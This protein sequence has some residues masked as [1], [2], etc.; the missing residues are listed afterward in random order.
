[1]RRATSVVTSA[2][3]ALLLAACGGGGG[4][5]SPDPV[6]VDYP[7][8]YIERP[9]P[10]DGDQALISDDLVRPEAFA[11]GARLL[12]RERLS[13]SAAERDLTPRLYGADVLVDIADLTV[14]HDGER[15][16]FAAR[17]PLDPDGDPD[18]QPPWAL[19]EYNRSSDSLRRLI[20]DDRIAAAGH[21][22][23]PA[24]LADGRIIFSSSRQRTG[25]AILLD[26]GRP[27]YS[28]D[29]E[30][31]QG[32]AFN[33]HVMDADGDNLTQ[34]TFNQ[35]HD[36]APLVTA[37][38]R[39]NYLRWDRMPGRD[40][41]HLYRMEPGGHQAELRY[42]WHSHNSGTD[43]DAIDYAR[44]LEDG[45]GRLLALIRRRETDYYGGDL[46]YI[47][48][49]NFID[50]EQTTADGSGSSGQWSATF[51]E[52]RTDELPSPAGRIHS[53]SAMFDDSGRLLLSWSPCRM[54]LNA[55]AEPP[56]PIAPCTADN[57]A[58]AGAEPAEPLYGIWVYNPAEQTQR[59]VVLARSGRML[60]EPVVMQARP[61]PAFRADPP[62]GEGEGELDSRGVAEGSAILAIRSVYDLD[63]VDVAP[64][65]I[66]AL[67]DPERTSSDERPVHFV[68]FWRG[69]PMP[70][71]DVVD[72]DN[73]AF[74]V[75]GGQL[76][77]ELVG[78]A[79]VEPD[80]SVKVRLPANVALALELTD[81]EGKRVGPRHLQWLTLQSGEQR[82][83]NGCHSAASTLPHGR[84]DAEAPSAHLGAP[85]TG[86]PYP[87]T[88]PARFADAGETMAEIVAR[89]DGVPSVAADLVKADLWTDPAVRTPDPDI[90]LR[91]ADMAAGVPAGSSCF[92][93]WLPACRISHDYPTS[94]QP[95]WQAER[96]QLDELEMEVANYRCT[97]CHAP[98]DGDG[99]AQLPA[100]Q[101]DLSASPS[102]DQPQQAV[103]FRE[104]LFGD[105]EQE[106]VEG[107]V[108]DRL[109][110]AVD[111]NGDP[112]YQRD[113]NGELILDEN[114]EPIPV[115]V[116]VA[117]AAPLNAAGASNNDLF[118]DLFAADGSHA[119]YLNAA[120]LKQI[121]E[122]L[123]GGGQYYNDPFRA[124]AAGN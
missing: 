57:M 65:G 87:N 124:A 63:G 29:A 96:P 40:G 113:A 58:A 121:A 43:G 81:G 69:V 105:N 76:M 28:G 61:R 39:V 116:T 100:G 99:L 46:I 9:L 114:G 51:G 18:D 91:Y 13:T 120:E 53:A 52:V 16:L 25:R 6:V 7:L 41:L 59:P 36:L 66:A 5:Q 118:F 67:A 64:G 54:Q 75:A 11:A 90:S 12:L 56:G 45:D 79:P 78:Y 44:L 24:Y 62:V 37:D 82:Q 123:D 2:V 60:T 42:G 108:R 23:M 17:G 20:S 89:L 15:L 31:R 77:R 83:C 109:V 21:D 8:A 85:V 35:S 122:W 55:A 103:S 74:G 47:D 117:I 19:W 10:R 70:D 73:S 48:A 97:S 110:P 95:L 112:I 106:L 98:V 33:L 14:S 38:G 50:A 86:Q 88:N 68:R 3:A 34:L 27:Q 72:F 26:E 1:M 71:D 22:R 49:D 80:G 119:G 104:L 32:P 111:G 93:S 92:T 30:D 4:S 115:L 102:P 101:L 84:S 94:I 107:V